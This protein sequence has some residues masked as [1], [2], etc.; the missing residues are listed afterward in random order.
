MQNH[1]AYESV[2]NLFHTEIRTCSQ[3]V[4]PHP[5][6]YSQSSR[7]KIDPSRYVKWVK[8]AQNLTIQI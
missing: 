2:R 7:L 8:L 4:I 3:S 1:F 5:I 6:F